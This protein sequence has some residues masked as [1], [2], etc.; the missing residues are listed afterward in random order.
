MSLGTIRYRHF[1][2][3]I[4]A[5][6]S[7]WLAVD[8]PANLS[9]HNEPGKD[10]CSIVKMNIEGAPKLRCRLE[11][12]EKYGVHPVHRLD[13]ETSGV[14]LLSCRKDVFRYFADQFAAQTVRKIYIALLHGFLALPG[15]SDGRGEWSW[16]LSPKPGGRNQSA[17]KGLKQA[18]H[19]RFR[20][21]QYSRHYTLIECEPSTGRLHQLRRHAVLAGHSIV[22]DRRYGPRRAL[23][24]LST[25]MNFNRLGLHCRAILIRSPGKQDPE[26]IQSTEGLHEIEHLFQGDDPI[27]HPPASAQP[28]GQDEE[29][30]DDPVGF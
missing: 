21:L 16:P 5:M 30:S 13:Q 1:S 26:T 10:L 20:I 22:G 2:I 25:K 4:L 24:F 14:I 17:G 12:H 18:C 29:K 15:E 8:K 27:G 6:G 19:T 11:Y 23:Q 3:P 7:G 9:V 28:T